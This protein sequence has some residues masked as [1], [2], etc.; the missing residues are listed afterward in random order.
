M[1]LEA[2]Y[3][4]DE[5]SKGRYYKLVQN[6]D[7]VVAEPV[8]IP[9]YVIEER[10]YAAWKEETARSVA[11]N[12]EYIRRLSP[13][14]V[15]FYSMLLVLFAIVCANYISAQSE[16]YRRSGN[17][18]SLQSQIETMKSDNDVRE[19]RLAAGIDFMEVKKAASGK[20]GMVYP[21]ESQV[22]YYTIG[23]SDYML[24][25]RSADS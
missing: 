1:Q 6:G 12:R 20:L 7:R 24:Q 17:I 15:M 25:Y 5:N 3:A 2:E 9:A 8:K 22:V 21:S 4:Y 23:D 10:K 18:A 16:A 11:R 13:F 14:K 19:K